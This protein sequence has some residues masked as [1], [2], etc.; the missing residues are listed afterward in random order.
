MHPRQMGRAASLT[1]RVAFSLKP[2]EAHCVPEA[3]PP[4]SL[5]SEPVQTHQQTHHS[6]AHTLGWPPSQLSLPLCLSGIH[7]G[8]S[9]PTFD[10]S[11]HT[12]RLPS[13]GLPAAQPSRA[14][15]RLPLP[16]SL[17]C[18]LPATVLPSC[19]RLL[20]RLWTHSL[21]SG[22]AQ[23]PLVLQL[24]TLIITATICAARC[25]PNSLPEGA[26]GRTMSPSRQP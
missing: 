5:R 22:H 24:F 20:R 12:R 6:R 3:S 25:L 4:P 26:L 11:S 1:P 18:P 7:K 13:S 17:P 10:T 19:S 14:T 16:G 2:L 9:L 23:S 21:T 15:P 8:T